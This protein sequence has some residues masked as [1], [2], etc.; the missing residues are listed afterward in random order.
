[1]RKDGRGEVV[2]KVAITAKICK[3]TW[4]NCFWVRL[5]LPL[6]CPSLAEE[7]RLFVPIVQRS[8]REK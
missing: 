6:C 1:M 5:L 2:T 7:K 4:G 3:L 8:E